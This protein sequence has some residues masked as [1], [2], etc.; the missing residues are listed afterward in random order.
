MLFGRACDCA[1]NLPGGPMPG[2]LRRGGLSEEH[3][4]GLLR[5]R[6]AEHRPPVSSVARAERRVA[7][8]HTKGVSKL[9][10]SIGDYCWL[11]LER[12]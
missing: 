6:R 1:R 5:R 3:S 4:R 11:D 9:W 12:R 10:L 2:Q 8:R 7:P